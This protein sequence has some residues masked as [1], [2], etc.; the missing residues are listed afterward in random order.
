MA[1]KLIERDLVLKILPELCDSIEQ[2]LVSQRDHKVLY[3]KDNRPVFCMKM[4]EIFHDSKF[5]VESSEPFVK[6]MGND[7]G[8]MENRLKQPVDDIMIYICGLIR[9][10][11]RLKNY[12]ESSILIKELENYTYAF[13]EHVRKK[14]RSFYD[15]ELKEYL[16]PL[17]NERSLNEV[18]CRAID[19]VG[20]HGYIDIQRA[21]SLE[22]DCKIT[23]GHSFET[24]TAFISQE[25]KEWLDPL[26]LISSI[27]IIGVEEILPLM[28]EAIKRKRPLIIIAEYM[29]EKPLHAF[30]YNIAHGGFNGMFIQAP[31]YGTEREEYLS[32]IA[33]VTDSQ[34]I[35][36]ETGGFE[37]GR[38][39]YLGRADRVTVDRNQVHIFQ[40]DPSVTTNVKNRIQVL[41][42]KNVEK[43]FIE[44]RVRFLNGKIAVLKI[45][46]IPSVQESKIEN[47]KILLERIRMDEVNGLV[48]SENIYSEFIEICKE[49]KGP[50]QES[51]IKALNLASAQLNRDDSCSL[52]KYCLGME[53]A[54]STIVSVMNIECGVVND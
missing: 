2:L 1:S 17:F 48:D 38:I 29:E 26:I 18:I 49:M 3:M 11:V 9:S 52:L 53:M 10:C 16:L 51:I 50:L 41:K 45:G 20:V 36:M 31:K 4:A 7:L 13:T 30:Q 15:T 40:K 22:D 44:E 54:M 27:P 34:V 12:Y 39:E 23:Q 37:N 6:L 21:N 42:D 8:E 33:L 32:D 24:N 19:R 5:H 35:S 25:K 14:R 46:G 47:L 28:T 43:G